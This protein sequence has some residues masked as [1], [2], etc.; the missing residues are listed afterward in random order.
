MR[1]YKGRHT[2]NQTCSHMEGTV[3]VY[4]GVH[5]YY[6]SILIVEGGSTTESSSLAARTPIIHRTR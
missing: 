6:N 3:A 5:E 4:R 2:K 1:Q